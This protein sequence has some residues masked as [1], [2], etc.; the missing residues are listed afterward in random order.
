MENKS[1]RENYIVGSAA[2]QMAAQPLRQ[3]L[4]Q[5]QQDNRIHER[6]AIKYNKEKAKIMNPGYVFFLS[7]MTIC[8]FVVLSYYLQLRTQTDTKRQIIASIETEV[9][10]L[11]MDN[12]GR[13]MRAQ[14]K[15]PLT[16]IRQRATIELGMNYP[17]ESQV[18]YYNVDKADYMEQLKE[19]PA[20][21]EKSL[22][23][24]IFGD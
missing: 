24:N 7:V 22:L 9:A 23:S 5:P 14:A 10:E 12:D 16:E 19:I 21:N 17:D 15:T 13:Y 8:M 2:R 3:P 20:S 4:R 18:V 6:Q 11:K 1:R